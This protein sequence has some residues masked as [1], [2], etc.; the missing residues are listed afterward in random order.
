MLG[1]TILGISALIFISYGAVSLL[2]PAIPSGL[3]GLE[4]SNGDAFAEIGAMYG[5]LQSG[6]GMFCLLAFLK[7]EFYRSGLALLV[8]STGS[9]ALARLFSLFMATDAV[10]AYTYGALVYELSTAVIAAMALKKFQNDPT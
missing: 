3:A 4:M 5:G 1:K 9:L 8:L 2:S 10:S 6:I 7:P